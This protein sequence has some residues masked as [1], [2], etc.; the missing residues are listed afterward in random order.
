M[1]GVESLDA[2]A[3]GRHHQR[4]NRHFGMF[5]EFRLAGGVTQNPLVRNGFVA[6]IVARIFT[7]KA[8][9]SAPMMRS[10]PP[11]VILRS[12]FLAAF[13]RLLYL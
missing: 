6:G 4:N 9:I 12:C 5:F 10:R 8:D 11:R 7:K 3:F 2:G 13:D 1:I